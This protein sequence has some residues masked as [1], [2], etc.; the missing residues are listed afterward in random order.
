MHNKRPDVH[1]R[2]TAAEGDS[3]FLRQFFFHNC[4]YSAQLIQI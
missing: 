3:P 1:I 2:R 4:Q